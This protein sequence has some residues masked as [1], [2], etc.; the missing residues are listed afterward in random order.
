VIW[1][2]MLC[3]LDGRILCNAAE[4]LAGLL[5]SGGGCWRG[6]CCD[7]LDWDGFAIIRGLWV[8]L[9]EFTRS[10]RSMDSPV[11]AWNESALSLRTFGL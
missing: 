11:N 1:F 9:C 7:N 2:A 4:L 8:S 3:A 5:G 6:F 10:D